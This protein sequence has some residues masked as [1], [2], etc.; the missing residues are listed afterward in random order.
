MNGL[1]PINWF[2]SPIWFSLL[3]VFSSFLCTTVGIRKCSNLGFGRTFVSNISLLSLSL[4]SHYFIGFL[5]NFVLIPTL[6][7]LCKIQKYSIRKTQYMPSFGHISS[8]TT[9]HSHYTG[10]IKKNSLQGFASLLLR[11]ILMKIS[12]CAGSYK[13][14]FPKH[15][16]IPHTGYNTHREQSRKRTL[17]EMAKWRPYNRQCTWKTHTVAS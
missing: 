5:R 10:L 11:L 8:Q 2:V 9:S 12:E 16:G 4:P 15:I 7:S 6:C 1:W 13:K 14:I 3:K 17:N